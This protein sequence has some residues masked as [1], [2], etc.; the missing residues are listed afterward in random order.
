[1]LIVCYGIELCILCCVLVVCYPGVVILRLYA[2][3]V[4]SFVGVAI[5]INTVFGWRLLPICLFWCMF[6]RL[7]WFELLVIGSLVRG[8]GL[9]CVWLVGIFVCVVG[10]SCSLRVL[11]GRGIL[12]MLV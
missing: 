2:I 9:L 10:F 11:M 5:G 4:W 1:M 12:L 3:V 7:L 8:E 6:F